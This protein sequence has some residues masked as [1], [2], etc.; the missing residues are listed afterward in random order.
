MTTSSNLTP[1]RNLELTRFYPSFRETVTPTHAVRS[2]YRLITQRNIIRS[3]ARLLLFLLVLVFFI[4]TSGSAEDGSAFIRSALLAFLA[5][6][7][8][9][10]I[11]HLGTSVKL[12]LRTWPVWLLLLWF[13]LTSHWASYPD[14]SIRRSIAF[15]PRSLLEA[16][17]AVGR[18]GIQLQRYKGLGEMNASQLWETTLDP[19]ERSLL[20]VKVKEADAADDLFSPP[21]SGPPR[22]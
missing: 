2:G 4:P 3:A 10:I 6:S 9:G 21:H 14:I 8:L 22:R 15:G 13:L 1:S 12:L 17:F 20:Q 19:N 18:K 5:I 7:M 11:Q 16:V